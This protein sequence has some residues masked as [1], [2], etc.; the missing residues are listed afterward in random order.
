MTGNDYIRQHFG[1]WFKRWAWIGAIGAVIHAP[2]NAREQG[3]SVAEWLWVPLFGWTVFAAGA[4]VVVAASLAVSFHLQRRGFALP[5]WL[6][7]ERG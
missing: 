2:I 6:T 1:R 7:R 4:A 3:W 5:A